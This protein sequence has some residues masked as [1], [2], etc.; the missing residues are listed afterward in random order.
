MNISSYLPDTVSK[1]KIL[2]LAP[3]LNRLSLLES[4]IL[5]TES[6]ALSHLSSK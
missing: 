2:A 6:A 3:D 1:F 5:L 4:G